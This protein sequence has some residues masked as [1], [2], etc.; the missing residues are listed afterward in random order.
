MCNYN[1]QFLFNPTHM[2]F[3][4]YSFF[5]DVIFYESWRYEAP[6][7]SQK[8]LVHSRNVEKQFAFITI[9]MIDLL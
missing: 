8:L 5:V 4:S 9:C 7:Q 2:Y 1:M 3:I 6:N